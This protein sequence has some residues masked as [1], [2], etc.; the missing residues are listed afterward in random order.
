LWTTFAAAPGAEVAEFLRENGFRFV[1]SL[2]SWMHP[3]GVA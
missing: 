1:A 3:C 2:G